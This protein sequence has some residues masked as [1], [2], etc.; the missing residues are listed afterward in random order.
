MKSAR[1]KKPSPE[2]QFVMALDSAKLQAMTLAERRAAIAR[3]ASLLM[4]AAGVAATET[5]DERD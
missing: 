1:Q 3:L 4:E 5:A 2:N